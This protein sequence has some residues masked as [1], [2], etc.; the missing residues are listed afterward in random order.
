MVITVPSLWGAVKAIPSIPS[1]RTQIET[2]PP[3]N[4]VW[5]LSV[6][7]ERMTALIG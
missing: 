7:F 6:A 4:L 5:T 2:F 3:A 1:I